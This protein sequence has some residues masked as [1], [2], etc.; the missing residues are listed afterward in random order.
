MRSRYYMLLSLIP[1]GFMIDECIMRLF[2]DV[3]FSAMGSYYGNSVHCCSPGK[4]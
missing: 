2:S 3:M 4:A 1:N